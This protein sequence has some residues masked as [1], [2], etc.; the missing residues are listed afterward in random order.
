MAVAV[1]P[2]TR[3]RQTGNAMAMANKVNRIDK[4]PG[5]AESKTAEGNLSGQ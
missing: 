3:N 2:F 1:S 5:Q 4:K